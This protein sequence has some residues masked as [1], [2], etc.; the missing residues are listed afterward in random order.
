MFIFLFKVYSK[1]KIEA[2]MFFSNLNK[3]HEKMVI[4]KYTLETVWGKKQPNHISFLCRPGELDN[5]FVVFYSRRLSSPPIYPAH[6]WTVTSPLVKCTRII[7][8]AN[9]KVY[10]FIIRHIAANLRPKSHLCST[11]AIPAATRNF[12]NFAFN[13]ASVQYAYILWLSVT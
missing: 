5:T 12:N 6:V 7:N 1:F 3:V 10:N 4:F 8:I 2:E 13:N 9:T 11:I